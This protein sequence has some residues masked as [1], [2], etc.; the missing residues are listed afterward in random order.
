M[1]PVVTERSRSCRIHPWHLLL[2]TGCFQ[3]S[4]AA[5]RVTPSAAAVAIQRL[6][7]VVEGPAW[8]PI[9]MRRQRRGHGDARGAGRGSESD[10]RAPSS[11]DRPRPR[12]AAPPEKSMLSKT[13]S[14]VIFEEVYNIWLLSALT[15]CGIDIL[16][17][18]LEEEGRPR[19]L[20][21]S[22]PLSRACHAFICSMNISHHVVPA[23]VQYPMANPMSLSFPP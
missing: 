9:L 1:Y 2:Q 21:T 10:H 6:W 20:H 12:H 11:K 18:T 22:L 8:T 13:Q 4:S 17:R 7:G 16:R 23:D 14:R 19:H 5:S 15:S 3:K